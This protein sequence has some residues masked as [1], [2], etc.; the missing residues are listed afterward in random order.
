MPLTDDTFFGSRPVDMYRQIANPKYM[1][2]NK[3]EM[4]SAVDIQLYDD[5]GELLYI[6]FQD[7]DANYLITMLLSES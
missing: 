2:W 1:M 4:V 7:W 5:T 3:N 6:P